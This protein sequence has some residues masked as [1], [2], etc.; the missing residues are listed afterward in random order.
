MK[1]HGAE[2]GEWVVLD[3][4]DPA[5]GG[6]DAVGQETMAQQGVD[7]GAFAR[8][9]FAHHHHHEQLFQLPCC[10][11][12]YL[13]LLYPCPCRCQHPWQLP[14]KRPFLCPKLLLPP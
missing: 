10:R 13:H 1:E 4:L 9:E 6:G 7:E 14:K 11:C 5:G 12:H 2:E 3:D 8:V